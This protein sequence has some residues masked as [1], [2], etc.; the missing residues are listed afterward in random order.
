MSTTGWK[1]VKVLHPC[2]VSAVREG[3]PRTSKSQEKITMSGCILTSPTLLLLTNFSLSLT[4]DSESCFVKKW[5]CR[6]STARK[7]LTKELAGV[8]AL[9]HVTKFGYQ[10]SCMSLPSMVPVC[11]TGRQVSCRRPWMGGHVRL[12]VARDRHPW[13]QLMAAFR[14]KGEDDKSAIMTLGPWLGSGKGNPSLGN[15]MAGR[16]KLS[17]SSCSCS[18]NRWHR[19]RVQSLG[20]LHR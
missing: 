6:S 9:V 17:D 16:E 15:E 8:I 2:G 13:W 14:E 7:T 1:W 12:S 3:F 18:H 4:T 5:F 20:G 19:W 10:S 11:S